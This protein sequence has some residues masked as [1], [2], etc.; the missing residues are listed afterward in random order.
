VTIRNCLPAVLSVP[1]A[2]GVLIAA[3]AALAPATAAQATATST[4]G[5]I[6]TIA[7]G[8]GGPALAT[9]VAMVPP[10]VSYAGGNLYV[11]DNF[12]QQVSARGALATL[13]G[14]LAGGPGIALGNAG[15]AAD[16]G[17]QATATV[18]A[19]DGNLIIADKGDQQVRVVPATTGTFFGQRMTAGDIYRI[20]GTGKSGYS[21]DGGPGTQAELALPWDVVVDPAGNV[22][23]ADTK[24]SRIRVVAAKTGTFYGQAM[25]TGDIYTIAGDGQHG[26]SGNAGPAA[27]A[28]LNA[29][30]GLALDAAGNL[31][32][33]DTGNNRIRVVAEKTGTFYG[34]AMTAGD[35]YTVAGDG[36]EQPASGVPALRTG[37]DYPRGVTVDAAGNVI[38]ADLL[39]NRIRVI[40]ERTGTF[41]GQAMTTGDIYTIAGTGAFAFS[42]DGGPAVKAALSMP[43]GVAVDGSGNLA[44]ADWDNNRIRVIAEKTGTFYG[45][46]MTAGDI[47]TVAGNGSLSLSGNGL[48]ATHAEL[49]AGQLATDAAGDVFLADFSN[50]EIRV[51]AAKTGTLYGQA[52]T[53]GGIYAI[54]GTGR[55]G[56]SGNNGRATV[57]KLAFPDGVAVDAAGNVIIADTDNNRIRMVAA[58]TGT[59]YGVAMTAGD[60]YNLAGNGQIGNTGDG[61]SASAAELDSPDGVAVDAAGNVLV[62]DTD[63]N[64]IRV[65]AAST[66][67]FYGRQM[68]AG[69]IY[70]VAGDGA[71]GYNGDGRLATSAKLDSPATVAV[72][73]AGNVVLTDTDGNRVRVVA[74]KTGTFYGQTMTANDIYTVAGDGTAGYAGDGS[75]ATTARLD[76]PSGVAVDSAGNLLIADTGNVR[77]RVVA[78]KTGTF[79]GVAM[80][81][82]HIYTVAG[83]GT[84][85][86]SGDGGPATAADLSGPSDAIAVGPD[87]DL[88]DGGRIRQVAG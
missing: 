8:P 19:P 47:Y 21:G 67:H 40:A 69:D 55:N 39:N 3:V 65:V 62:A 86:F 43:S 41:Y 51:V 38:V 84:D 78:A 17:L 54:A 37:M 61:G 80:T 1:T 44:I 73:A 27:A 70:D 87:I 75:L 28:A 7:G 59:F 12:V 29:P 64:M 52:M 10:G 35:I 42:G 81:A 18:V 5:T 15:P 85:G 72:D 16:A 23:I 50:C 45:V 68:T 9:K 56:Y 77:V 26:F 57:A 66:G 11:S 34:Q 36:K 88:S 76:F 31:V 20:A 60:I 25:T 24:N 6:S 22:L 4:A 83:D 49:T 58:K 30:Q 63:N 13:A 32:I 46:P 33:T 53:A 14:G 82:D 48:P 79:Y 2:A 71:E 74:E